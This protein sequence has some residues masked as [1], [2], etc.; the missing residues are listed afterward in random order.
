MV[1]HLASAGMTR[2]LEVYRRLARLNHAEPDA[3]RHL[4]AWAHAAGLERLAPSASLW[5]YATAAQCAWWGGVWAR[6]TLHSTFAKQA[7]GRGLLARD[8]LVEVSE[9]WR[10]WSVH[11]DA[12]FAMTRAEVLAT[13]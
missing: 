11:P 4:V 3:G 12:W 1:W 9:A 2:W 7:V 8:E 5:T 10:A 6:R 13:L